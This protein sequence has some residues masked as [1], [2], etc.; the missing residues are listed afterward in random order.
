VSVS[1]GLL[2]S[3]LP[4]SLG[5][6]LGLVAAGFAVGVAGHLSSSRR[7]VVLGIAMIALGA[8]LMPLALNLTESAPSRAGNGR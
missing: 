8:F 3:V 4:H 7:L 2:A 1:L 6:Y 5:P